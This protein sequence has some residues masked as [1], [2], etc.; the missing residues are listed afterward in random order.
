MDRAGHKEAGC[1]G[2]QDSL[3]GDGEVESGST[4]R[5]LIAFELGFAEFVGPVGGEIRLG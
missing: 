3:V 2:D 4:G 1:S 5:E